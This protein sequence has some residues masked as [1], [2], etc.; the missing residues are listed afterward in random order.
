MTSLKKV[1]GINLA[2]LVAYSVIS[3]IASTG[4][5]RQLQVMMMM[6]FF[7]CIQVG[8]N[9]LISTIFFIKKN[10]LAGKNFLLSSLIVLLIGFSACWGLSSI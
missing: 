1:A 6:A 9:L 10:K 2:I 5:E 8:V 7:I 4:H 3:N